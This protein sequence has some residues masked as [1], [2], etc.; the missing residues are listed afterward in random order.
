MPDARP[1]GYLPSGRS[2]LFQSCDDLSS[3]GLEASRPERMAE[4]MGLTLRVLRQQQLPP[5]GEEA[6]ERVAREIAHLEDVLAGRTPAVPASSSETSKPPSAKDKLKKVVGVLAM[7]KDLAI[8]PGSLANGINDMISLLWPRIG[9]FVDELVH[10]SIEPSINASLPGMLKGGVKF[11]KVSLG[12][13]SP[14]LG[15]IVVEHDKTSG[16]IT[17]HVGVD[18]TS[19]LDIELAA[20]GI[21]IGITRI[22]L[23]GDL[24]L[25]FTPPMMKPPFFG[26]VQVYFPNPPDVG[27]NFVGAAKLANVPGLR[28]AIRGAIDGGVAGVCVLPRRIAVDMNEDDDVDIIDLTYPEPI[29]ILR[30]TLWSAANLVASDVSMFGT[31]TSDPYVV[32][33]LG[34]KTWTSP[35]ISKT[36]NPEWG[37]GQGLTVDFPVHDNC[38]ALSLKVLDYDFGSADDLIGMAKT[39]GVRDLVAGGS[40]KQT[41][42]LLKEDGEAG[43]G[44]LTISAA[45]LTFAE[46]R[47]RKALAVAGPSEAHLSAKIMTIKGLRDGSDYPF[48]VRI[49]VVRSD[50]E[51]GTAAASSST[52]AKKAAK[53][54]LKASK[55]LTFGSAPK[56][57]ALAEGTTNASHPKEQKQLADALQGIAKQLNQKGMSTEEVANIL[58]V[59]PPQVEQFLGSFKDAVK[60]KEQQEAQ[61]K[62]LN[63]RDPLFEEVVQILLPCGSVDASSILEMVIV[64]K[65]EKVLATAPVPMPLLLAA[66]ELSLEGPF[67][68]DVV[69]VEV[70]GSLHLRWL[71]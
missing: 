7:Q 48:K 52:V 38:Q 71:A 57:P 67:I 24:V 63:V 5:G 4:E 56:T 12:Q 2:A 23:K 14:L 29:G 30:F 9:T 64:D 70:V 49:Q 27:L 39:G 53:P 51:G 13:S 65:R 44:S 46:A 26:G 55:S 11:T 18:F 22:F 34:I 58:D 21:P 36:L 28:G 20:M 16:A 3:L 15:P 43:G 42:P 61:Q 35:H 60:A 19:D 10:N 45:L 40:K 31:A 59:A 54:K 68:T 62:F 50:A 1:V 17:M 32:A 25:L 37:E 66:P 33:S 47:P 41:V 6:C 8:Q 69:D